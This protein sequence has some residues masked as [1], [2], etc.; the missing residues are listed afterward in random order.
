MLKDQAEDIKNMI[1]LM[2]KQFYEIR[3]EN[4]TELEN[5]ESKFEEDV[6]IFIPGGQV[7]Y[8]FWC[9]ACLHCA[10]NALAMRLQRACNAL[11]LVCTMLALCLHC[12]CSG[13]CC[14]LTSFG[15]GW[16]GRI[17]AKTCWRRTAISSRSCLRTTLSRRPST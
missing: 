9:A 7:L 15:W 10:C 14:W 5:I 12:A 6:I 3:D 11:A 2:R 17:S 8:C 4:L 1:K 13:P 16:Y